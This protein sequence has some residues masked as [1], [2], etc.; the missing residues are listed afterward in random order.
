MENATL[1]GSDVTTVT[2]HA[3]AILDLLIEPYFLYL[4][5]RYSSP[6]MAVYRWVLLSVSLC[7]VSFAVVFGILWAAQASLQGYLLCL[8]SSYFNSDA[9][10]F[11]L[12]LSTLFLFGQLQ[13]LLIMLFYACS[14]IFCPFRVQKFR[15]RRTVLLIV[16]FTVAPCFFI[17]PCELLMLK[18]KNCLD[19][20]PGL[21]MLILVLVMTLYFTSY[22]CASYYMLYRI[23]RFLKNPTSMASPQTIAF[24]RTARRNFISFVLTIVAMDVVPLFLIIICFATFSLLQPKSVLVSA[25]FTVVSTSISGYSFVSTIVTIVVT[26]PFSKK[27]VQIFRTVAMSSVL[28]HD[29]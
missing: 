2:C 14:S 9:T 19:L 17:I 10:V 20:T 22:T 18:Q 26:T 21:P 7:N 28:P 3:V 1:L 25:L 6:S 12:A 5:V 11:M 13:L 29:A 16:A 15:E 24:V 23:G 8:P 4:V 27:T